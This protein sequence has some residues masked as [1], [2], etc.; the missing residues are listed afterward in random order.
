MNQT[1]IQNALFI[2]LFTILF[3]LTVKLFLPFYTIIL[4][5]A[6]IY[7]ITSPLYTKATRKW[8]SNSWQ[9]QLARNF[10]AG[11]FAILA[12]FVIVIPL[13][14]LAILLVNQ[15][16]G[17]ADWIAIAIDQNPHL[18][19]NESIGPIAEFVKD[20]TGGGVNL[21][22]MD[23]KKEVLQVIS[24]SSNAIV[25]ASTSVIK[26]FSTFLVSFAFMIFSLYFFF[27]D[28]EHLL[29]VFVS[30]V[31]IKSEHMDHFIARF[32]ETAQ[33]LIRGYL[34]VAVYQGFSAFVIFSIFGIK[35]SALLGVMVSFCSF[36]PIFGAA[37]I[38][39]PAGA[40]KIFQGDIVGGI[41]VLA[42]CGFFVSLMDNFIRPFMIRG[43]RSE[44]HPLLIFFAIVG[45]LVG[46]GMNGLVVGPLILM[47][48]F[49]ALDLFREQYN[50]KQKAETPE[51]EKP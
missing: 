10:M 16:R 18:F 22:E 48:F 20:L 39:F 25:A 36:I 31:P 15:F 24:N 4:W 7:T 19:A 5:A 46:F 6:L 28:G 1:R 35:G 40:V 41:L 51:P 23:I 45:G 12:V 27:V 42:L 13:T 8:S 9:D 21:A 32:K 49:T 14:F 17:I 44:I 29:K 33:N 26:G 38:W 34:L 3:I 2:I 47:L 30:A 50:L 37:T 43:Q 11:V